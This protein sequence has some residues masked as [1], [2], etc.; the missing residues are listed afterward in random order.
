M[1]GWKSGAGEIVVDKRV[2]EVS[3][4][5]KAGSERTGSTKAAAGVM[6]PQVT[7]QQ[8]LQ[9]WVRLACA[10]D[11][12]AFGRVAEFYRGMAYAVAYQ[13]LS[14]A[15]LAEDAVQEAFT[16]A[17]MHL[18]KLRE[19]AAFA[20]WL[21]TIVVRQC[22]RILRSKERHTLLPNE[23]T[24]ELGE[25]AASAAEVAEER[26]T[27]RLL[28]E[29]ASNLSPKLRLPLQLFYYY[30]YSLQEISDYL[31]VSV[32]VLKKRLFDARRKLRSALPV[33]DPASAFRQLDE[34]GYKMLHIVNGDTVGEKLK[35]GIVQGEVL[36][37]RELYSAGPISPD[38]SGRQEREWRAGY[39]ERAFGIPSAEYI[40][41]CSEQERKLADIAAYDEVVLWFEHDLFDQS[42]LAYL[43]HIL[44]GGNLG[45]TRLSLLSIGEFPG[46]ELFHGLGQ[47]TASQ[48]ETLSGTW[49]E[50][51]VEEMR[52]GSELWLAYASPQPDR[53]F[54][55]LHRK[56]EEWAHSALP[57]AYEA[58]R[59]HLSRLPSVHNGLGI[60][61]E[62]TLQA[63]AQG[64]DTPLALFR[65]VTDDLSVLGMGDLEF[66]RYL[67]T[68]S[69]GESPLLRI[70][71]TLASADYRQTPQFLSSRVELTEAGV[72]VLA[73]KADR[74]TLQGIDEWYGGLH[75]EGHTPSWRWDT[76]AG[77]PVRC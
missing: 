75:L 4:G 12:D 53:L 50:I 27:A 45:K 72:A 7:Q 13:R 61:E 24:Q 58:F 62:K 29:A 66:W 32:P 67:R 76:T 40:R 16:E 36:V 73:G 23:A 64:T 14:D 9:Q 15:H 44:N 8:A 26:E 54:Q 22:Q 31:A 69:Q 19:P 1:D 30:G 28:K 56:R 35:Q 65:R 6:Q 48:L 11:V 46:I 55:L 5:E 25:P 43:L 59:A 47:L 70:D 38:P 63:V 18:G 3:R 68:L 57:F 39:L 52:W 33:A 42:M 37:W 21:R 51:G 77:Q 49:R 20:G 74:V 10:G 41:N 2:A 34:G 60:V 17:Y 71:G